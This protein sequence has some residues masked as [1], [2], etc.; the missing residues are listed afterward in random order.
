MSHW[1]S[2][3]VELELETADPEQVEEIQRLLKQHHY[4]VN[5]SPTLTSLEI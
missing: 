3:Q 1:V 4:F 2:A 5:I